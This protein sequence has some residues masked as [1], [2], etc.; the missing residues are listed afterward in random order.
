MY[1][2]DQWQKELNQFDKKFNR[3]RGR[4][5]TFFIKR[6]IKN[7]SNKYVRFIKAYFSIYNSVGENLAEVAHEHQK[8]IDTILEHGVEI[9]QIA[10]PQIVAMMASIQP[11]LNKIENEFVK[12]KPSLNKMSKNVGT[13]F[14]K[15]SEEVETRFSSIGRDFEN[16]INGRKRRKKSE[17]V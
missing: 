14:V 12:M 2:L 16:L 9:V 4:L 5:Q 11:K 1:F 8:E 15:Y 13:D 3:F 6:K 7:I 17:T 10:L